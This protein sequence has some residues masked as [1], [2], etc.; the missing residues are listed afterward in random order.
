MVKIWMIGF[1]HRPNVV[2]GGRGQKERER[3][4]GRIKR[5]GK[6]RRRGKEN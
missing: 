1:D 5:R 6:R 2:T 4:R 3:D